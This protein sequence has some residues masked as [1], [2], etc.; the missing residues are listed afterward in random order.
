MPRPPATSRDVVPLHVIDQE[1]SAEGRAYHDLA[2][3]H[4]VQ[5]LG[6]V[7]R[8]PHAQLDEAALG[9]RAG[10]GDG[11]PPP[12]RVD[13]STN[14][15]GSCAEPHGCLSL[16]RNSSNFS[17]GE[18]NDDGRDPRRPRAGTGSPAS[19]RSPTGPESAS[20][21]DDLDDGHRSAMEASCVPSCRRTSS[22]SIG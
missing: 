22:T 16:R 5:P 15:P 1:A 4:L 2:A 10:Y 17:L 3:L 12:P 9:R 18:V 21:K 20:S 7:A 13:T 8:A 19:A 11:R 14:W 6:E